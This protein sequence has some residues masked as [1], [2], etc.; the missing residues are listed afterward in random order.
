M[1]TQ[2]T[3][4]SAIESRKELLSIGISIPV[5]FSTLNRLEDFE[6]IEPLI[7]NVTE[8]GRPEGEEAEVEGWKEN[9]RILNL[10][11]GNS[12]LS[13]ELYDRGLKNIYNI[14]ISHVV[15]EQ[16]AMRNS[17]KRPELKCKI[18]CLYYSMRRGGDGREEHA[19][20]LVRLL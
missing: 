3:G 16:M 2:Y 13:E 9:V 15:I 1:V 19:E 5:Y 17:V 14:D 8:K 6:A 20:V 10:G 11:C 18:V 7:E 12:I 4:M